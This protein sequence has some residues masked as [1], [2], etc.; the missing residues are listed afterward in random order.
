MVS[1]LFFGLLNLDSFEPTRPKNRTD[2]N[3]S[4]PLRHFEHFFRIF[5]WKHFAGGPVMPVG[6]NQ[7]KAI[8]LAALE[9]HAPEIRAAYLDGACG[10][11]ARLRQRVEALLQAHR[12]AAG[13][14]PLL[15]PARPEVAPVI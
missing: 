4:Q 2:T 11:D 13:D 12:E 7:V 5:F 15:E 3:F 8:F 9:E 14:G 10:G 6:A 1:V